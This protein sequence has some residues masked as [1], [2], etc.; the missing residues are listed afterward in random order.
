VE[1]DGSVIVA[2]AMAY[3][4][5][6]LSA[7]RAGAGAPVQAPPQ[8]PPHKEPMPWPVSP[9]Y[10]EHE[11]V[12]LMGEV[13]GSYDGES[14]DHFHAGLDVRADVGERVLA[15][16]QSK[17]T[18]PFANWGFGA[19]GEGLSVGP[20]SYI[21]MR[22]GRDSRGKP[23]DPRFELLPDQRGK[24]ERVRVRRGTRF[25]VGDVLGTVNPMSHVHL[26]YYPG[27]P[28]SNP[29]ALPFAG[30][31]DSIAPRIERVA[32]YD[33]SNHQLKA[34]TGKRLR[35]PRA[36]GELSIVVEAFDQMDDNLA[37]RRLGLYK[38]GYQL[39]GADGRPMPGFEQPLVTQVYD[40]L[41]R[42]REAVKLVYAPKSG[43]TVYGSKITRFAYAVTNKLLNGQASAGSWNVASLPPGDYVLRAYVADFGGHT[44][45]EGRDLPLTIE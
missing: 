34:K 29:L 9:Q 25:A 42:N 39:L 3:R 23:L 13:R 40:R 30:V 27:G 19:I 31:K 35:V 8:E 17:V 21:H 7:S 18:D 10:G 44:A 11:V 15:V 12:G 28:L 37:R 16:A 24:P 5:Q 26:E 2:D 41:P 32:L 38:L 33:S 6:R 4:V 1:R 14:R 22:V 20:L 43:I 45:T 36:L